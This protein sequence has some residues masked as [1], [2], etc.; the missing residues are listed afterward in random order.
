MYFKNPK[1]EVYNNDNSE[2]IITDDGI[3][4]ENAV[5]NLV[6]NPTIFSSGWGK[7][8]NGGYNNVFTTE[9]GTEAINLVNKQS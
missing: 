7:Y 5:T 3:V 9:F 2:A 8:S 4:I 6:S 1:I